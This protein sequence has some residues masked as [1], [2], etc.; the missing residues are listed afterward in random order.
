MANPR[1]SVEV[2]AWPF[3]KQAH[4]NDFVG[5]NGELESR[6]SLPFVHGKSV[7]ELG[8]G[9]RNDPDNTAARMADRC[10]GLSRHPD[11]GKR[12]QASQTP[13]RSDFASRNPL[14]ANRAV[15][16]PPR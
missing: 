15:Q 9:L 10:G 7:I 5:M 12:V 11:P 14:D 2:V 13:D 4:G 1:L 3:A 6:G 8:D 16:S